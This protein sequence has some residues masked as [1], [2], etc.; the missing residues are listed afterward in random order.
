MWA[1][2]LF[3]LLLGLCISLCG[4]SGQEEFYSSNGRTDKE[5]PDAENKNGQP[6]AGETDSETETNENESCE[7][8]IYVHVCG[9]VVSPGVYRLYGET[10]L[11]E[12][13]DLA[14]G[15]REDA[16]E[17]AVNLAQIA[18]DGS[19]LY[20]PTK[21]EAESGDYPRTY[22]DANST[23][24][25]NEGSDGSTDNANGSLVN[26]NSASVEML[27]TLPGIGNAKA[28]AI[29]EYRE[30]NGSFHSIEELMQV[31]GIGSGVFGALKELITV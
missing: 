14:G 18:I 3:A 24:P 6:S 4:C 31:S 22:A 7:R 8:E 19:M 5:L 30:Q 10:R 26:I 2:F 9:A 16:C 29:V 1:G 27:C 12:L 15:F 23:N 21:S 17:T 25:G 28:K 13:I 20:I 11:F